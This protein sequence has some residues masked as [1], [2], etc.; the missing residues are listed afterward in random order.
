VQNVKEEKE[1][2]RLSFFADPAIAIRRLQPDRD[3][4]KDIYVS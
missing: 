3:G 2:I 1:K 4:G